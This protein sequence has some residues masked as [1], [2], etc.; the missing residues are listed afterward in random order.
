VTVSCFISQRGGAS[1]GDLVLV[2]ESAEALSSADP[3]L[4]EVDLRW[5]GVSLSGCEPELAEGTVGPV[6][7]EYSIACHLHRA[8]P[9][10]VSM[11]AFTAAGFSTGLL[12]G[13]SASTRLRSAKPTRSESAQSRSVSATTPSAVCADAR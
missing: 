1:G 7:L 6:A 4:S 12:L 13:A 8:L 3:V 11:A 10:P 5:P 9:P 2:R